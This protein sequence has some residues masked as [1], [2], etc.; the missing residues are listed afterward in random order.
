MSWFESGNQLKPD[1]F[2][3]ELRSSHCHMLGCHWNEVICFPGNWHFSQCYR[4]KTDRSPR[5]GHWEGRKHAH[6]MVQLFILNDWWPQLAH[7]S[8][9]QKSSF[10]APFAKF[11]AV[12]FCSGNIILN[13]PLSFWGRWKI[14]HSKEGVVCR[15][16]LVI[17]V[18]FNK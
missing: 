10:F 12:V 13:S 2:W 8:P 11:C 7:L 6:A 1:S 17:C 9:L 18:P 4:C 5:R 15:L 3:E 16:L 14:G